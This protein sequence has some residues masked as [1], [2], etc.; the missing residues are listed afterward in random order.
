M[1]L[2]YSFLAILRGSSASGYLKRTLAKVEAKLGSPSG[3]SQP[4]AS[5]TDEQ[6]VNESLMNLL[7]TLTMRIPSVACRWSSGRR[8]F[9]AVSFGDNK[10]IAYMDGYLVRQ[11]VEDRLTP[12]HRADPKPPT[13]DRYRQAA[14]TVR[15]VRIQFVAVRHG[16]SRPVRPSDSLKRMSRYRL[17]DD[18][19]RF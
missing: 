4:S 17:R 6:I 15:G 3:I 7:K 5:R 1:L 11:P 18:I 14:P 2:S 13:G 19:D 12:G 8:P 10:L 9:N 16:T